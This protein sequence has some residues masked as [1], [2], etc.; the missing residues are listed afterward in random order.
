[1]LDDVF[2]IGPMDT[3]L[4]VLRTLLGQG[5][6]RYPRSAR[7]RIFL[8]TW[9][10]CCLVL[11]TAYTSNLV[12]LLTSPA[13]PRRVHTLR[14]LAH[15]DFRCDHT[16]IHTSAQKLYVR[17]ELFLSHGGLAD[18]CVSIYIY[19]Y[20]YISDMMVGVVLCS[21]CYGDILECL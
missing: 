21:L 16:Y 19:I 12:A 6:H 15:S 8:A 11:T 18:K 10:I 20:I 3:W 5:A 9:F 7:L 17:N 13:Y 2:V 4:F 1:M 14:Q